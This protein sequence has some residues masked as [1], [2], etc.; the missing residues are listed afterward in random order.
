MTV[1]LEVRDL[2]IGYGGVPLLDE[3]AFDVL[4]GQVFAILGG[5]GCGKSTLLRTLIGLQA[6]LAGRVHFRGIGTPE[7][8]MSPPQFGVLFQSAALF[9]SWTL[10]QNVM[11]PLQKWTQLPQDAVR[12]V[13]LAR[14]RLVGLELAAQKLPSE[15]SGGMRKRAGIARALALDPPILFLDE[16]SAGLDPVTAAELDELILTLARGLSVT[17]VLVTHELPSILKIADQ[18][19]MLDREAGGV[20]ARGAPRDLAE[21]AADPRV[22]AF[23]RRQSSPRNQ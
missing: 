7:Q 11:L 22:L 21:H 10:L 23:F 16:P 3:I 8:A 12:E 1:V 19:L 13:A 18:C 5:S 14:L 20:I 6:P 4:R 15:V 2:K 9:G 17:I